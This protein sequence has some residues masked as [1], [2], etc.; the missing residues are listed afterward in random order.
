MNHNVASWKSPEERFVSMRDG[1]HPAPHP[2][3]NDGVLAFKEAETIQDHGAGTQRLTS[4]GCHCGGY[5]NLRNC[6]DS[7]ING[8]AL[9]SCL[10]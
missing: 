10:C 8:T 7:L 2:S 4:L 6:W 3:G 1:V 9:P 5:T